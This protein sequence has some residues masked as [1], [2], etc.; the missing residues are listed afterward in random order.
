MLRGAANNETTKGI[1]PMISNRRMARIAAP[2]AALGVVALLAGCGSDSETV[3]K[4]TI[5]TEQPQTVTT[6]T[7]TTEED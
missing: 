6:T 3:T 1:L 4:R 2:L 7:T 5:T